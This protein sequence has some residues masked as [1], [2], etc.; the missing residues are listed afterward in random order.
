MSY[1]H[2]RKTELI[3]VAFARLFQI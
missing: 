1:V 2:N 3:Q